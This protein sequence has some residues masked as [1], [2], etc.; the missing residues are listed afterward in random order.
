[1]KRILYIV[2]FT[3]LPAVVSAQVEKSVEVTKEYVPSVAHAAKLPIEPDLVDTVV[4]RP[5]ID[6]SI[7]PLSM[8]STLTTVPI[9]PATVTYWEFNRPQPFYLKLGAGWPLNSVA[10]FYAVTQNP[11]TGYLMGYINHDGRYSDVRNDFGVKANSVQM[12]NRVG[13][14]A[15]KYLGKHIL[16]GD[17]YYQNRLFHRYGEVAAAEDASPKSDY[18]AFGVN[19]R[20]GD[21]FTDLSRMNFNV[22]L[23]G[24][25]FTGSYTLD[26]RSDKARQTHLGV[27]LALARKFGRH[28]F[29]L[30]GM[31]EHGA[32]AKSISNYW[33]D[34]LSVGVRYGYAGGVVG[35]EIGAD[36]YYD[37]IVAQQE[38]HYVIPAAAVRFNLGTKGFVPYFEVDGRLRDNSFRTL[39]EQNPYLI[40]PMWCGKSTAEYNFRLGISGSVAKE[41]LAYRIFAGVSILENQIYW[42][43][44]QPVVSD[45]FYGFAPIQARQTVTSING[46]LEFKPSQRFLMT[47]GL[48]GYSYNNAGTLESGRATF[49][50][51]LQARY[52]AKKVSFGIKAALQNDRR[53]SL[54]TPIGDTEFMQITGVYH[55]PFTVDLSADVDWRISDGC[56]L[57]GEVRNIANMKLY[58][59]PYYRG[60]GINF[61]VGV[62]LTF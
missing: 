4:L 48:H 37:K 46:E 11:S 21:D 16:E 34:I 14:A 24:S 2:L 60:Y 31:Y 15:G 41:K 49:E 59:Y 3:A 53:W 1:M 56:S 43:V 52:Q 29:R 25:L 62:K 38:Q 32:G 51:T 13:A 47:L 42:G 8:S 58:D 39:A 12:Y 17:F 10:D 54:Y 20:F 57:F 18:G 33:E 22:A 50:G 5:D 35:F 44:V 36:Y 40:R 26:E 19:V 27:D 7:T 6:Y 45:L 30:Q 23:R 28:T 61:T 9:R 55:A